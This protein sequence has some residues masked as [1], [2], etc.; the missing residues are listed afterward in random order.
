MSCAD[1]CIGSDYECDVETDF[2]R[3]RTVKARKRQKC[4]ECHGTI[5]RGAS[6]KKITAEWNGEHGRFLQ[7]SD[8]DE[9]WEAFVCGSMGLGELHQSIDDEMFPVWLESGRWD[10]LAKLKKQSAIDKICQWY[11]MWL[12]H[13]AETSD[14]KCGIDDCAECGAAWALGESFALGVDSSIE[15]LE[16]AVRHIRGEDE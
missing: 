8:C 14:T 1:V 13:I 6:Y 16:N 2:Y 7:C 4:S 9:I 15:S 5:K 11:K 12:A 10:C 3:E